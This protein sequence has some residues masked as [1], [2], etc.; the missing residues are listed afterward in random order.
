MSG[1]DN[2]QNAKK[3]IIFGQNFASL[4]NQAHAMTILVTLEGQRPVLNNK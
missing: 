4:L 3:I 1:M 2:N